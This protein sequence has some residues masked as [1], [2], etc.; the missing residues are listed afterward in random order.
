[1]QIND[2]IA[3]NDWESLEVFLATEKG[4][5]DQTFGGR[6]CCRD[7]KEIDDCADLNEICASI[8]KADGKQPLKQLPEPKRLAASRVIRDLRRLYNEAD[9]TSIHVPYVA[10]VATRV[11]DFVEQITTDGYGLPIDRLED[12]VLSDLN[13]IDRRA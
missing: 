3:Q 7:Y 5:I 8:W 12:C 1:M 11:Y 4:F 6:Y 2:L 13:S 10:S 9:S